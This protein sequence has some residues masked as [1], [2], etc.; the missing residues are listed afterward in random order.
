MRGPRLNV[1]RRQVL[2]LLASSPDGVNEELLLL[3][4]GFTR[5]MLTGLVRAGLAEREVVKAGG[6]PIEVVRVRITAVGWRA[7]D[8]N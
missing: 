6:K 5:R 4:H 8:G 2:Q 7:I 1:E 3:D